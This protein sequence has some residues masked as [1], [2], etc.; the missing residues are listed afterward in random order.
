MFHVYAVA[1]GIEE[2]E[3]FVD[4]KIEELNVMSSSLARLQASLAAQLRAHSQVLILIIPIE[5]KYL[6]YSYILT[7]NR[8]FTSH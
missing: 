4:N 6:H 5:I 1:D 8:L 3:S 2:C 7:Y